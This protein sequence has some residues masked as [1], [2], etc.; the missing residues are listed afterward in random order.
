MYETRRQCNVP[1]VATSL[2]CLDFEYWAHSHRVQPIQCVA[3]YE[4]TV[5]SLL[6][7]WN[8]P[9]ILETKTAKRYTQSSTR[10]LFIFYMLYTY[11]QAFWKSSTYKHHSLA[12]WQLWHL[13]WFVEFSISYEWKTWT[14]QTRLPSH[15][16][17]NKIW[18]HDFMEL[19]QYFVW[20]SIFLLFSIHFQ[21]SFFRRQDLR[22]FLFF[23][24]FIFN[25]ECNL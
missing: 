13:F 9:L 16:Q 18:C 15:S 20:I 3:Q 8:N 5:S 2:F 17:V 24:L 11:I 25:I 6:N 4:N 19:F 23:C 7:V 21:S 14:H 1:S 22:S 10:N 12:L